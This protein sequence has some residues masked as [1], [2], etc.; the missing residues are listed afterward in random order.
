[1]AQMVATVG[2]DVSK[3]RL[4]VAVHPTDEQFSVTND[5]GG[6]RLL[7]RRLRRLMAR[8]VGIEASGGYERGAIS[9]LLEAGLPVRSVNPWKLR[10]FAKAAGVLAKNDRLDAGVIAPQS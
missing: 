7:V 1:M 9:A 6:W 4:D 2:I 8:G 3:D 10:L 5:A